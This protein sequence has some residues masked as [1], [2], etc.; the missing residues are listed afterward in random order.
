MLVFE[1]NEKRNDRSCSSAVMCFVMLC[2]MNTGC[3]S[4][5]SVSDDA[6]IPDFD[7]RYD[8]DLESDSD[9]EADVYYEP[10]ERTCWTLGLVGDDVPIIEFSLDDGSW[11]ELPI[12][13]NGIPLMSAVNGIALMDRDLVVDISGN[14]MYVIDLESGLASEYTDAID[15]HTGLFRGCA[16]YQGQILRART[17]NFSEDQYCYFEN[18]DQVISLHPERCVEAEVEGYRF[19]ALDEMVYALRFPDIDGFDVIDL[20]TGGV[21]RSVEL[22]G[23]GRY[24]HGDT[25]ADGY[26]LLLYDQDPAVLGFFDLETG[27]KV[28]ELLLNGIDFTT[29]GLVCAQ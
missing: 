23:V 16:N 21:E 22:H 3:S 14:D 17:H 28:D 5:V 29:R 1:K 4:S 11:R 25:I 10:R 24:V 7:A 6:D 27:E 15:D 26:L 9:V 12:G 20:E 8:S 13:S 2:F 18:I 19:S